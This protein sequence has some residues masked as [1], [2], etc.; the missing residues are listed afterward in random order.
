[1]VNVGR[2]CVRN[3]T[4][5]NYPYLMDGEP[6]QKN[7]YG[8]ALALIAIMYGSV[9]GII[10]VASLLATMAIPGNGRGP[11]WCMFGIPDMYYSYHCCLASQPYTYNKQSLSM[12]NHR[13]PSL[14]ISGYERHIAGKPIKIVSHVWNPRHVQLIPLQLNWLV[15]HIPFITND[16]Y[17]GFWMIWLRI[18]LFVDGIWLASQLNSSRKPSKASCGLNRKQALRRENIFYGTRV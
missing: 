10:A 11:Q 13:I 17:R 15:N 9:K 2:F 6:N 12:S 3:V 7:I 8:A 5:H 18:S 14:S 4:W 16:I 1:M